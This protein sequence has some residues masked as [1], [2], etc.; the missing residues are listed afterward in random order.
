MLPVG[1]FSGG[2]DRC[3]HWGFQVKGVSGYWDLRLKNEEEL[4]SVEGLRNKEE[5]EC[6]SRSCL[7]SPLGMG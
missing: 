2:S 7:V 1:K 6:F 5:V 3:R 4:E